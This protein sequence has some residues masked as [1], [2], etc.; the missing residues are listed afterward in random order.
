MEEIITRTHVHS[1]LVKKSVATRTSMWVLMNSCQV[2]VIFRSGA[3]GILWRLRMLPTV[4]SL[5]A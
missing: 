5:M 4:W 3:G 2:M 1:A